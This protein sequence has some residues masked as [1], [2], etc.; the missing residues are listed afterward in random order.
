MRLYTHFLTLTHTAEERTQH[1]RLE[2]TS[3]S[4]VDLATPYPRLHQDVAV[5]TAATSFWQIP[6]FSLICRLTRHCLFIPTKISS[7]VSSLAGALSKRSSCNTVR[8]DTDMNNRVSAFP[9]HQVYIISCRKPIKSSSFMLSHS[10][11]LLC[12]DMWVIEQTAAKSIQ[13]STSAKMTFFGGAVV[14]IYTKINWTE[15]S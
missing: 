4:S 12:C 7:I 14:W 10:I 13:V 1:A 5:I 8:T 3:S 2:I 6:W 9:R 15:M 11:K